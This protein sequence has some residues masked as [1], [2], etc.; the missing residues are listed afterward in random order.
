MNRYQRHILLEEV[1]EK[2]QQKLSDARV[3]VIGAGGLGC[4]ALQYLS[5]AGVGTIGIVD[6]DFVSE[7]NL[8]RQVLYKTADI[9]KQKALAA[10]EALKALNSHI[11]LVPIPE[12]I[13]AQRGGEYFK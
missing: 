13:D 10:T 4:A 8:Q 6:G 9:G 3:L 5:A 2:G 12:F 11:D 1:G 7:T